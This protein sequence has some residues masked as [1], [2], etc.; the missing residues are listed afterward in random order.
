MEKAF[1]K[2]NFELTMDNG[3]MIKETE[4]EKNN[5]QLEE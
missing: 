3:K 4:W 2:T 5:L 1:L